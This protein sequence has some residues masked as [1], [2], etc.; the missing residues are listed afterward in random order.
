MTVKLLAFAG[1]VRKESMNQKLLE[2]VVAQVK[3]EGA[4]VTLISL[5]DYDMPFYNGDIEAA[6]FP[7]SVQK[8]KALFKSHDGFILASPE[9]NASFTPILKNAIDWVSRPMEG[10]TPLQCFKGKVAGLV[11][12]SPG[13]FGALRS[14]VQLTSVLASIG[15]LVLPEVVSVAFYKDA[16]NEDGTLKNDADKGAVERLAKRIVKIAAVK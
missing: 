16:F 1:S 5:E 9:Y 2:Q 6:G 14:I 7:E 11:G 13:K 4:E 3:A 10:E 12:T 15:T 8:L